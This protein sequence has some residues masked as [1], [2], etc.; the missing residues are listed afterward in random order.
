MAMTGYV[1]TINI[2][3]YIVSK[4]KE[5]GIATSVVSWFSLTIKAHVSKL[6]VMGAEKDFIL[7][8]QR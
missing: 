6:S 1:H 5:I 4:H 8:L 7:P 2:V 3:F